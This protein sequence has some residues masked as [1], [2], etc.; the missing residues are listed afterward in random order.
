[1]TKR[2]IGMSSFLV[3]L[4]RDGVAKTI[5]R[6]DSESCGDITLFEGMAEGDDGIGLR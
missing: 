1:M 5:L 6:G 3:H 2:A 4:K